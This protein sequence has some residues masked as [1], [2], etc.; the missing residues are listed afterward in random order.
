MSFTIRDL[1]I[2]DHPEVNSLCET[3]WDGNDYVPDSFPNW[4]ED[5][6]S[7]P[8]GMFSDNQLVALVNM[9]CVPSRSLAWVKGLRVRE[10]FRNQGHGSKILGHLISKA[11]AAGILNVLYATSSRNEASMKLA[12]KQGFKLANSVDYFRLEP[13]YP[14]HPKPSQSI[15]PIEVDELRLTE[16]LDVDESLMESSTFPVAWEFYRKDLESLARLGKQAKIRVV[17]DDNGRVNT[18]YIMA[19]RKRRDFRTLTFTVYSSNRTVFV[20]V[21]SRILDELVDE[22]ADRAAFFLGPRVEQWVDFIIDI[23]KEFAERRFLLYER[24]LQKNQE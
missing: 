14:P 13:P 23:P 10:E 19:V 2:D 17:I 22:R 11:N 8:F 3:I 16:I 5:K 12:E 15:H 6:F 1:T 18:L 24:E 9:E 4:I 7:F 21:F 20:D